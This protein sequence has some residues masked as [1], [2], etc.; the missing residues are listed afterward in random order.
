MSAERHLRARRQGERDRAVEQIKI[1]RGLIDGLESTIAA[2]L[3]S[4]SAA[5][6]VADAAVRL[7]CTTARLDAYEFATR[8]LEK[9]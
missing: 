6:S 9:P 4:T 3:P 5:Q 1:L 7:A 8:D 2:D